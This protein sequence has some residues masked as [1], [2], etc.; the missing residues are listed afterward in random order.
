M[1]RKDKCGPWELEKVAKDAASFQE[2]R[3]LQTE[4]PET[5]NRDLLDQNR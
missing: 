5:D 3:F 1:V 2:D 4:G